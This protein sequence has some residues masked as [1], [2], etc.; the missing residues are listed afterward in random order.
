MKLIRAYCDDDCLMVI[1]S[2]PKTWH[3]TVILALQSVPLNRGV[4]E[5]STS[6]KKDDEWSKQTNVGPLVHHWLEHTM[7]DRC[8][9]WRYSVST[10]LSK[11]GSG[12]SRGRP[13]ACG[14]ILIH[15]F[16]IW[17]VSFRC[18]FLMLFRFWFWN[19]RM[20]IP[21]S[22][23]TGESVVRSCRCWCLKYSMSVA[24]NP[25]CGND[26]YDHEMGLIHSSWW[27]IHFGWSDLSLWQTLINIG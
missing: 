17:L 21:K 25:P 22:P 2:K 10:K 14:T 18:C 3:S 20:M 19:D 27:W 9:P 24:L 16:L 6:V 4:Y 5:W 11:P 8:L 15:M 12:A 23:P 26:D 1:Y 13:L 7:H